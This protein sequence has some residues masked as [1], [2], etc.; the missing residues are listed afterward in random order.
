MRLISFIVLL[1]A[2]AG[3]GWMIYQDPGYAV[4]AYGHWSMEMPLWLGLVLIFI[5]IFVLSMMFRLVEGSVASVEK[6]KNWRYQFLKKKARN[7]TLQGLLALAEGQWTL[8]EKQ[9]TKSAALSDMPFVNY[10]SAAQAALER[11]DALSFEKYLKK[12][13]QSAKGG[14]VAIGITKAQLQ[15]QQGQ[16]DES[17]A[18][19]KPLQ[20]KAPKHPLVLTWLKRVQEKRQ[21]WQGLFELLPEIK[22]K[23]ILSKEE[24]EIFEKKLYQALMPSMQQKGKKE[25]LL[26]WEKAPKHVQE[27][28][29]L[30][31]L[32][33]KALIDLKETEKAE[34]V[35]HHALKKNW[36]QTL[37]ELY[38]KVESKNIKKQLSIA[39]A[40]LEAHQHDATLLLT[41]GHLSVANA[42]WGKAKEYFRMSIDINPTQAAFIGMA[43]LLEQ[44]GEREASFEY[45]K[46]GVPLLR[47]TQ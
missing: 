43:Q 9:L 4:L 26:F 7:N 28:S 16:L 31:V 41:L 14:E 19:L 27:A 3:F 21:D 30:V 10:L 39:E 2:A 22:R 35:L 33:A 15:F 12:A 45:Y 34:S 18:T 5:T 36:D 24:L 40:W 47:E 23:K 25:I 6:I 37:V 8:A 17:L 20:K 11:S 1:L 38:G 13:Y 42:L 46:K 29:N 32:Y 44:L